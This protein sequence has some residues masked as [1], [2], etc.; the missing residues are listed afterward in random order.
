MKTPDLNQKKRWMTRC[1]IAASEAVQMW[2]RLLKRGQVLGNP[3]VMPMDNLYVLL[4][5]I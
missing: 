2:G 1:D 5:G 4:V 3:E